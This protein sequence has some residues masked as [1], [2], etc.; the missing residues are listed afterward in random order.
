VSCAKTVAIVDDLSS[1]AD[2]WETHC[3]TGHYVVHPHARLMA[4]IVCVGI[5]GQI[6]QVLISRGKV[7]SQ[8]DDRKTSLLYETSGKRWL[9][10]EPLL[11]LDLCSKD[12]MLFPAR[13]KISSN[14]SKRL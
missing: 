7:G 8:E 4:D 6:M 14:Q 2:C 3:C 1:A 12:R 13:P 5:S 11:S 10:C 9:R